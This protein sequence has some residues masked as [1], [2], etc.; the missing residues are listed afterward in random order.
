MR[1]WGHAWNVDHLLDQ[2]KA[3]RT[4]RSHL[5]QGKSYANTARPRS[6]TAVQQ[7]WHVIF[8]S[9][10]SRVHGGT[11]AGVLLT[12]M[13]AENDPIRAARRQQRQHRGW[14]DRLSSSVSGKR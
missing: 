6:V 1:T 12:A 5:P 10:R 13:P 7:C 3:R 9:T 4:A 11:A 2:V 8:F 14:T